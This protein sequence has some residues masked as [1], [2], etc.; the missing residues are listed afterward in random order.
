MKAANVFGWL[1]LL[2]LASEC[3]R[4]HVAVQSIEPNNFISTI[5]I[6]IFCPFKFCFRFFLSMFFP[7]FSCSFLFWSIV[8]DLNFKYWKLTKWI[9]FNNSNQP[10]N[11]PTKQQNEWRRDSGRERKSGAYRARE[12][13]TAG[14]AYVQKQ[15]DKRTREKK[16]EAKYIHNIHHRWLPK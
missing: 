4:W 2:L 14:V 1:L 7:W 12:Y 15:R 9:D 16:A 8:N 13:T 11:Q 3:H 10:T 5:S 6:L